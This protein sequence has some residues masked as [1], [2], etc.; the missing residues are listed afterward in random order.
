LGSADDP[1]YIAE[2]FA[3]FGPV[4]IR[5]MFGGAGI[6]VD[7]MM[8]G[9]IADG[10]IYLKSDEHT[11]PTFKREGLGPF[12]YETKTGTHTLASYWRMPERLYDDPEELARWATQ[13]LET[14]RRTAPRKSLAGRPRAKA[15]PARRRTRAK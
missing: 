3:A 4:M 5:R 10:V 15:K 8:F 14:A 9:L 2:L 12:S 7:G 13:A 6:F 1:E 11:I